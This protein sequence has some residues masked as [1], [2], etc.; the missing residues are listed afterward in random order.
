M[1]LRRNESSERCYFLNQIKRQWQQFVRRM[2]Q[3]TA[4]SRSDVTVA[5]F[6]PRWQQGRGYEQWKKG[7]HWDSKKER[8]KRECFFNYADSGDRSTVRRGCTATE[9]HLLEKVVPTIHSLMK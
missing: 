5:Y 8:Y 3:S 2:F 4:L 7:K 6:R 9:S 1:V